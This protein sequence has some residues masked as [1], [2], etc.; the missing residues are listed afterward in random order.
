[1]DALAIPKHL[2]KV[3]LVVAMCFGASLRVGFSSSSHVSFDIR[4]GLIFE[5]SNVEQPNFT[6]LPF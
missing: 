2:P 5:S 6:L 1:M 3:F 4:F